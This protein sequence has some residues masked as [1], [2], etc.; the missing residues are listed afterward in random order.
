MPRPRTCMRLLQ[1]LRGQGYILGVANVRSVAGRGKSCAIAE[2]GPWEAG[3]IDAVTTLRRQRV[4]VAVQDETS[5]A[6]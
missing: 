2:Y 5:T 3:T 1:A 4:A 6:L